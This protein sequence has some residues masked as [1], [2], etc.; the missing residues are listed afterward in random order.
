MK[1]K[2]STLYPN[3]PLHK[4]YQVILVDYPIK[5][6]LKNS[7]TP[8]YNVLSVDDLKRLPLNEITDEEGCVILSWASGI[9][10]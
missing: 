4:K 9:T 5:Y 2:A 7:L 10:I 8:K 6:D 1:Y 3:F